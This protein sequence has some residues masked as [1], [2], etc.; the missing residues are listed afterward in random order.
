MFGMQ[1]Y[2]S[3]LSASAFNTSTLTYTRY[4]QQLCVTASNEDTKQ[5]TIQVIA[6]IYTVTH[7]YFFFQTFCYNNSRVP[8]PTYHEGSGYARLILNSKYYYNVMKMIDN[9]KISLIMIIILMSITTD[10]ENN[11]FKCVLCSLVQ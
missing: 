4:A 5:I 9:E 7:N 8:D 1:F 10:E 3:I 11:L 6:A 2:N